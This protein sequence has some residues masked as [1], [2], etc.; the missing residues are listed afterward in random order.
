MS[1]VPHNGYVQVLER[2]CV[3][4]DRECIEQRLSGVGVRPIP[5]VDD[6]TVGPTGEKVRRSGG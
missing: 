4:P 3:I 6:D 2:L 5:G 1:D